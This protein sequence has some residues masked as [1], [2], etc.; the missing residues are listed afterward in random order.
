MF[1]TSALFSEDT[2]EQ[3]RKRR[4]HGKQLKFERRQEPEEEL[5]PDDFIDID[6][7]GPSSG[8]QAKHTEVAAD[9]DKPS[10]TAARTER[11]EHSIDNV[12]V[13]N[14]FTIETLKAYV[15][16]RFNEEQQHV[17]NRECHV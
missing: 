17:Q 2:K 3:R 12:K 7:A 14:A 6:E 5:P 9:D 15:E 8:R 11:K 13:L 4:K 10:M 1:L 16:E